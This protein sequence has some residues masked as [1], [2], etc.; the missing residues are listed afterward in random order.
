MRII[1][2]T[3]DLPGKSAALYRPR[4]SPIGIFYHT[5]VI[6]PK[7]CWLWLWFLVLLFDCWSK[8]TIKGPVLLELEFRDAF[9]SFLQVQQLPPTSM[10]L[11]IILS[12]GDKECIQRGRNSQ[13]CSVF[14]R[15]VFFLAWRMLTTATKVMMR[16]KGTPTPMRSQMLMSDIPKTRRGTRKNIT[17]R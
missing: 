16:T 14:G 11:V 4:K 6:L 9:P 2:R 1:L 5:V 15:S 3:M 8:R 17:T 13:L 7:H 10:S 12:M